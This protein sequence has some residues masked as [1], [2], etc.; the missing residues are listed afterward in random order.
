MLRTMMTS[1]IHR[2]TVTGA[3]PDYVGSV[4]VDS[5]L[6]EA[7]G[8][9]P[10]E[11]VDILDITNGARLTTYIIAD[12]HDSGEVVVNGAAAHL[13]HTGDI[14]ILVSYAQFDEDELADYYPNVVHVD[15]DNAII[16][17]THVPVGGLYQPGA[18]EDAGVGAGELAGEAAEEIAGA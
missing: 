7:S 17:V 18:S 9:L 10:G 8:M 14:V 3:D 4:S 15:E 5:T 16:E 2:A 12:E 13:V 1:K 6:L 11:Q